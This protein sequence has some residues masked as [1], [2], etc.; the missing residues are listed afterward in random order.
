[1][2][3]A[4]LHNL[5][6]APRSR[7]VRCPVDI[8]RARAELGDAAEVD[9]VT[10][11]GQ[12][13]RAAR[14]RD[15]LDHSRVYYVAALLDGAQ[16]LEGRLAPRTGPM[17]SSLTPPAAA[18][19]RLSLA[20]PVPPVPAEVEPAPIA[21]IPSTE[22]VPY[23]MHPWVTDDVAELVPTF[24]VVINGVAYE[25]K[26]LGLPELLDSGPLHTRWKLRAQTEHHGFILE[27]VVDIG[28][29][30]P[31]LDVWGI[32]AWSDRSNPRVMIQVDEV[33]MIAGEY[34]VDHYARRKGH[35]APTPAADGR[36][37]RVK[38]SGPRAFVDGTGLDVEGQMVA[39][40]S[41][42]ARV[43][44]V[45]P[46]K[47]DYKSAAAVYAT[48]RP[49]VALG[50]DWDGNL[51][52]AMNAPRYSDPSIVERETL[53]AGQAFF[54]SLAV[55]GD[56]Y[57]PR[58]YGSL[59][60]PGSTGDQEDFGA[61]KGTFAVVGHQPAMLLAL[62]YSAMADCYRPG[63]LLYEPDATGALVPLDPFAHG[64]WW[65]WSGY[66]HYHPQVSLDR[67]GKTDTFGFEA[68]GW[69]P[70]DEEHFGRQNLAA[71]CAL[72]DHP[73][74]Q[75][76][77]AMSSI[78]DS[79]MVRNPDGTERLG[80]ARGVGRTLNAWAQ[81]SRVCTTPAARE[82]FMARIDAR[83]GAAQSFPLLHVNGP[84]K[85][86][87]W[88]LPDL[89]KPI[90]WP[91]TNILAPWWSAWEHGL[92]AVALYNL[93]KATGDQRALDVLVRICTTAVREALADDGRGGFIL[94]GDLL[95]MANDGAQIPAEFK[96][97]G[98]AQMTAQSKPIGDVVTWSFFSILIA[99]EVLGGRD[100]DRAKAA[101]RHFTGGIEASDRRTAEWW[102]A[103]KTVRV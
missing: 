65:T 19:A 96:F 61:T 58:P 87:A 57:D 73:M 102:A 92:L 98:S 59:R 25:T 18:A 44:F 83:L 37:W 32:I 38:L 14:G 34:F 9:F 76:L 45:D 13:F 88:G 85:V 97:V 12:R 80:P 100:Q 90:Y 103:V 68:T 51:L 39:F 26:P 7:V 79:K 101:V 62:A 24:G 86:M 63:S 10:S 95:F 21:P 27:W 11:T 8:V 48:G 20:G 23:A 91:G 84:V 1:M 43:P 42:P 93:F 64:D 17:L 46:T 71:V 22:T 54:S 2:V 30:D 89:R 3:K 70:Y 66:T 31:V 35:G 49:V 75:W 72:Y 78:P 82:R 60:A 41:D 33:Y 55:P 67:I 81:F 29:N 40:V 52:A 53:A 56:Y 94:A 50:A 69:L 6:D 5:S 28:H 99:T 74:A 36:R 77:V 16:R 47:W 15:V 4:I